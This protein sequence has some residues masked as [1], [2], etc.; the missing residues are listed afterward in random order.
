MS[1]VRQAVGD[2][3]RRHREW[4]GLT[5]WQ[6]CEAAEIPRSTLQEIERGSTDARLSWLARIAHALGLT[7]GQLLDE[8][9]PRRPP[10]PQ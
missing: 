3:I 6:L 10:V 2:R 9:P 5:Q 4:R 7:P 8:D 1:D